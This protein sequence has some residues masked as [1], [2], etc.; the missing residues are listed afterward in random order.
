MSCLIKN[1]PSSARTYPGNRGSGF[2]T[3]VPNCIFPTI[4]IEGECYLVSEQFDELKILTQSEID[5]IINCPVRPTANCYVALQDGV[6][7]LAIN[8]QG[9][10]II[11]DCPI[12]DVCYIALQEDGS[13]P[14]GQQN[15]DF[16]I[17]DC[18]DSVFC[19]LGLENGDEFRFENG[20]YIEVVCQEQDCYLG[21]EDGISTLTFES[22]GEIYSQCL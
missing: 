14:L 16:F 1:I 11:A 22:F 12:T 18:P 20:T 7:V 2:P 15:G 13:T 3:V 6:T 17:V 4:V 19:Y 5:I 9:D 21:L 8:D 10:Y